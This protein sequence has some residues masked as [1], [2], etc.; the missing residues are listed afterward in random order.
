M[1]WIVKALPQPG[2]LLD[3]KLADKRNQ[4][5]MEP[6]ALRAVHVTLNQA[7]REAGIQI[8][9]H[10]RVSE[11]SIIRQV[12]ERQRYAEAVENLDW[13]T[14][15]DGRCLASSGMSTENMHACP[16]WLNPAPDPS[17]SSVKGFHFASV[18]A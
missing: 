8:H 12:F 9:P 16:S 15:G 2:I 14:T 18:N 6:P 13:W 5:Q 11:A 4:H 17:A 1:A 7:A 3:V 10:W